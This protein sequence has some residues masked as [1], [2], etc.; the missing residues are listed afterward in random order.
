MLY[1]CF[2]TIYGMNI[3]NRYVYLIGSKYTCTE[4]AYYKPYYYTTDFTKSQSGFHCPQLISEV[5]GHWP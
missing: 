4:E 1:R 3:L 2:V 5:S